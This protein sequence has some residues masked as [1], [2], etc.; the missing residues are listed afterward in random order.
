MI[1]SR[2]FLKDY[3]DLSDD[4]TVHELAENMTKVG[5]EYDSAEKLISANNLVI[6]EVKECVDHPDS[7]HLH[8]CKVDIGKEVTQIVC[9]APNVRAGLK[10]IVALPGAVLPEMK[11]EKAMKRG[12]ESNGMICALQE[13]GLDKKYTGESFEDGIH[14]LPEDAPV[15]EDPIKYMGL[16]DDVIDFDLTANR[17]DLLSVIG[18]AYEVGAIY[19]LKVKLPKVEYKESGKLDFDV[20]VSTENFPLYL[21]RRVENIKIEES[22]IEIREK[23]IASGIRPIN[24][25]V[26]I[27]N[28]VMLETGQPL[29][30][31][32]ADKLEKIEV[33]MAKKDEKL[34]TLDEQERTLSEEDIVI[35]DGQKPVA[36]AGVMGGLDTEITE[37]TKNVL[38]EAA[39]FNNVKVRKTSNR[40]LRSES[41]NRFEKGL[42]PARTYMAMDRACTMLE[43]YASGNVIAGMC[44]V[45]NTKNEPKKIDITVTNIN[46]IL[47]TTIDQKDVLDVFR[48][49]DF[50]CEVKDKDLIT[51]TVPTRRID[52]SIK[53]DLIEEVGRIYGVDNIEGKVMTLDVKPGSYNKTAREIRN[54]MVNLGLSETLSYVLVNEDEAKRFTNTKNKEVKPIKILDPLTEEKSTLRE[55][56]VAAL[57]KI[58]EYN[59][60]RSVDDI[61]IFELGKSFYKVNGNDNTSEEN[62]D[63]DTY[64]EE[65]KLACLMKG[66]YILGLDKKQVDFYVIKGVAEEILD[67]LGYNGRYSFVQDDRIPSDMHPGKSAVISVNNDVVGFIGRV[68]PIISKDEVYVMEINLDKL[69]EKQTGSMKYKEISKFPSVKKD[70]AIVVDESISAQELEKTI[71]SAGGKLLKKVEVFDVYQ[72]KGIPEGK[73]SIAFNIELESKDNTLTDAE[74]VEIITKIKDALVAKNKAELRA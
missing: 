24:N 46:N 35:T 72:G 10:V 16:D 73:R 50:E 30:F 23:L 67:Y 22:P 54:K 14:E 11:I 37:D 56:V 61:N 70:I 25:V 38:I 2:K 4:I 8:V 66:N 6:G 19:D 5:N 48:K 28:Y 13:I 12:V 43:K 42:D 20:K 21:A 15:G 59:D 60:A 51:V 49:L 18:M 45:D 32:D 74:I 68:S 44:K 3:I 36:L 34:V 55:T 63:S 39:I 29:H 7:D 58:Y 9:G 69:L 64:V 31:F 57:Y 26:D 71:K 33:R 52:I 41:S 27:S 65:N 1:L 40:I 47:G 17:G 53:E 62:L